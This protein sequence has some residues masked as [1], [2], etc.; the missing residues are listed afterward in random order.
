MHE[1]K[2]EEAK[3]LAIELIRQVCLAQ[4]VKEGE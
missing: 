1:I 4:I 3:K 2:M